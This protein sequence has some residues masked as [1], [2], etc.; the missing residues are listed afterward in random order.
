MIEH[1]DRLVRLGYLVL[2]S[3][4]GHHR[5]VIA[6]HGITQAALPRGRIVRVGGG[7]P[8]PRAAGRDGA[9]GGAPEEP[10]YTY[11]RQ[12]VLRAALDA[13]RPPRI[14]GREF[15]L[16]T[17][18]APRRPGGILPRVFGLRFLPHPAGAAGT[19][20]EQELTAA[21]SP[22][23]A[24]FALRYLEG[25]DPEVTRRLLEEADIGENIARAAVRAADALA[26]RVSGAESDGAAGAAGAGKPGPTAAEVLPV[27]DPCLLRAGPTD[28]V[29]RRRR[30]R[31]ALV[32]AGVLALI[33]G[34]MA[35]QPGD[36][37]SRAPGAAATDPSLLLRAD[38]GAWER[39]GR[40]D[41]TSWPARGPA[42]RDRELLDRVLAAWTSP[43]SRVTISTTRGTD[44][45]PPA[46]PP[47]LL[48]AGEVD[49]AVVVLMHDGLRLMRYAE[50]AG[51]GGGPAVLDLARTDGAHGAMASAVV[52]NRG[53]GTVRYL[54]AP[55]V[56]SAL[57]RD[58]R[59]TGDEGRPVAVDGH[60]ATD[61]LPTPAGDTECGAYPVLEFTT[62]DP[63]GPGPYPMADLGEL[64]PVQLT[65]GAPGADPDASP[66]ER[67]REVWA[68][69]AC[70]LS[71]L[72]GSGVRT[73]GVWEFARQELPGGGES[74]GWV[75]TRADTWRT[76]GS[77]TL[78]QFQPPRATD[79]TGSGDDGPATPGAVVARAEEGPECGP[80]SP[81]VLAGGLWQ[82]PDGEWYLLAAG[83]EE[84]A[85]ISATGGVS[86][87]V[88]GRTMILPAEPGVETELTARLE[89]GGEMRAL[90][91]G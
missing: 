39:A 17:R 48:Y 43:D 5:R 85:R 16:L 40:L 27:P 10:A 36:G 70:H 20:P 81:H 71:T 38:A 1:Y 82:A 55:W 61:A 58:L 47:R 75:C 8:S 76:A 11:V 35:V 33:A 86:G 34:L 77:R 41:F 74:A 45:G 79:G 90:G 73:V 72:A 57:V 54:T 66:D 68:S 52:L 87:E 65:S 51:A 80:R 64:T 21:A 26:G 2:P 69:T 84:V 46:G 30:T 78:V 29:R 44:P 63:A 23:R 32:S 19:V 67:D 53:E 88:M 91:V 62:A 28:L 89:D 49:G 12:R 56:S 50:A 25:L 42:A 59:E 4:L 13:G 9:A 83:S 15:P 3:S 37:G 22:T 7:V 24:A 6:A 14:A 31:T 18:V 60:G